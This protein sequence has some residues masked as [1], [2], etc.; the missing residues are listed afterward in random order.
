MLNLRLGYINKLKPIDIYCDQTFE[1]VEIKK[2]YFAE[3]LWIKGKNNNWTE[4]IE[5]YDI[6]IMNGKNSRISTIF[7]YLVNNTK[8][9]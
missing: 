9:F 5:Q 7:Y 1:S 4:P 2:S 6:S 3:N 8:F